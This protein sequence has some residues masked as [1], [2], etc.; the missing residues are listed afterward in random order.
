MA[1]PPRPLQYAGPPTTADTPPAAGV[2]ALADVL[3]GVQLTL[4]IIVLVTAVDGT[5][6]SRRTAGE[7]WGMVATLAAYAAL[8]AVA[9]AGSVTT[10]PRVRRNLYLAYGIGLAAGVAALTVV[11]VVTS[12]RVDRGDLGWQPTVLVAIVNPAAVL[13]AVRW[14]RRM[15]R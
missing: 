15:A 11:V 3:S 1:D 4:G 12:P 9:L 14:V 5:L 13:L 7:W 2:D 6:R 8:S 10:W